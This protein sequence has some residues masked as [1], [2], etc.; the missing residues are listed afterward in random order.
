ML[1]TLFKLI[2][3]IFQIVFTLRTLVYDV[4]GCSIGLEFKQLTLKL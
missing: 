4:I 1:L 3:Y 2:K